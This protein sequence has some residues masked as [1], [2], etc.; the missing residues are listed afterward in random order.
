MNVYALN[1]HNLTRSNWRQEIDNEIIAIL[2]KEIEDNSYKTSRWFVQ[3]LLAD[4]EQMKLAFV[5][6]EKMTDPSKHI[7]LATHTLTTKKWAH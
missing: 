6:R 1:E 2:N 7:V 5:T 3:S 4:A